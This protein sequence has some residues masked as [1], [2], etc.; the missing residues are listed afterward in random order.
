MHE[1]PIAPRA[2]DRFAELVEAGDWFRFEQ[3]VGEASHSLGGRTW[4]HVNS[5]AD[6]GGVAELLHALLGSVAGGGIDTRWLVID[7][8][9]RFFDVTKRVHNRLHGAVR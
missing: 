3:A 7:G 1:I 5:T 6:G 8:E 2:P 9:P 4:W